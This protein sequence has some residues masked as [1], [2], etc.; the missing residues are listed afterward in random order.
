MRNSINALIKT[1]ILLICSMFQV[2]EIIFRGIGEMFVR[3][4][5][6]LKAISSR[7]V[8]RLDS[9]KFEAHND[10]TIEAR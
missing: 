2:I 7:M 6:L 4:S 10:S 1:V 8:N 5:D 3:F 9:G